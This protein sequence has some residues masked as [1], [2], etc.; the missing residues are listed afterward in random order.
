MATQNFI[1]IFIL[2][3][4]M[5]LCLHQKIYRKNKLFERISPKKTI[6]GFIGGVV[7]AVYLVI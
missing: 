5:I 3:G 7:F 1:S 6:E 2:F 4:P